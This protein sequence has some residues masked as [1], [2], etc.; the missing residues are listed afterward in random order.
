MLGAEDT[1]M[2]GLWSVARVTQEGQVLQQVTIAEAQCHPEMGRRL[3][4]RGGSA[5]IS[6]RNKLFG[7]FSRNIITMV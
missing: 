4:D 5:K 6:Q 3:R 2:N 7:Y 1:M